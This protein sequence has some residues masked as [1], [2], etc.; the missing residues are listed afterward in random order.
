MP[1]T[2]ERPRGGVVAPLGG[3]SY[4]LVLRLGE[5]ERFEDMHR[6]IFAAYDALMGRGAGPSSREVRHLVALGLVGAGA[7]DA[8]A[9]KILE[10]LGPE[11]LLDLRQIALGL[12]VAA[13]MPDAVEAAEDEAAGGLAAAGAEKKSDGPGPMTS[14]PSSDR[15]RPSAGDPKRSAA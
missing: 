9:D 5:I 12:V 14:G 10:R 1:L 3:V 11:A 13:L 15:P 8:A 2:P 7:T 4:A 6:S